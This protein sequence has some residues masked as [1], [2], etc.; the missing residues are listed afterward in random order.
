MSKPEQ[1]LWQRLKKNLPPKTHATRIE[2]RAGSGVP[3][4][5]LAHDGNAV[6]VELK[7]AKANTVNMR[8]SQIAWNMAYS[9]A[10]GVSFILVSRPSKGD[11]FLFEGGAALRLAALRI[12]VP[13]F[14]ARA[15]R[16]VRPASCGL[17]LANP[18]IY[19]SIGKV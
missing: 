8:P 18:R 12:A 5:H 16:T 3:D 7:I 9:A 11:V 17:V 19:R 4:V 2:N 1:S 14:T 10:G 13:C 15:L 6:W